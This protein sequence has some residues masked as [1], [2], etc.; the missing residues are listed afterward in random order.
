MGRPKKVVPKTKKLKLTAEQKR[1]AT[2][3]KGINDDLNRKQA[4]LKRLDDQITKL[5]DQRRL[6]QQDASN[7]ETTKRGLEGIL[8]K[9][10]PPQSWETFTK[11]VYEYHYHYHQ[12]E[13]CHC[14]GCKCRPIY[15]YPWW[16]YYYGGSYIYT[17]T[18]TQIVTPQYG[19]TFGGLTSGSTTFGSVSN[20]FQSQFTNSNLPLPGQ[21]SVLLTSSAVNINASAPSLTSTTCQNPATN[22][23][24]C[25]SIAPSSIP[26]APSSGFAGFQAVVDSLKA[27]ESSEY[28][29]TYTGGE[30]I[31]I[32]NS[33][34][35]LDDKTTVETTLKDFGFFA[36]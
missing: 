18:Y 13:K 8:S 32:M 17:P 33:I 9:L 15:V 31:A 30:G 1:Y 28:T 2:V 36:N 16:Q 24:M 27:A 6:L 12:C 10:P 19:G 7:L 3:L 26:A 22:A 4:A 20:G 35:D 34:G 14:C 29:M 11:Y 23:V 5:N 21:N 25:S